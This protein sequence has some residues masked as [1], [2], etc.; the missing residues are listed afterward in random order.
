[1]VGRINIA[2]GMAVILAG[3]FILGG[4][5]Q[6]RVLAAADH[7]QPGAR[8]ES[9]ATVYTLANPVCKE[10]YAGELKAVGLNAEEREF[11]RLRSIGD[12]VGVP[13]GMHL[14]HLVLI[15]GYAIVN[16]VPPVTIVRLLREKPK[17][18][19]LVGSETCV[20]RVNHPWVHEEEPR[21]F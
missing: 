18:R 4:V 1:M 5:A 17:I 21:P 3:A 6:D 14:E 7:P 2:R 11:E 20:N 10:N 12:F 9:H 16:H 19:G 15:G 13:G 8:D